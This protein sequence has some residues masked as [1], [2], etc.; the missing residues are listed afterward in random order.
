VDVV[1]A[2]LQKSRGSIAWHQ[3]AAEVAGGN[4]SIASADTLR[5]FVMSLP[6]STYRTTRMHPKLDQ[7]CKFRRY[8]WTIGFWIFWESAKHFNSVAVLLVHMDE[9]W[10]YAIVVRTNNKFVPAL[11]CV[12]TEHAIHHQSHIYTVMVIASTAFLPHNNDI[13]SG[14]IGFKISF[15][16]VGQMIPASR[17]TYRRQ[18][19]PEGGWHHPPLEEN[20]LRRK[21]EPIFK[22]M[23]ITG[24]KEGMPGKE[25]Y[26]LLTNF[27]RKIELPKLD[28]VCAKIESDIGKRIVV[29]YQMDG[30][31]PHRDT[32]LNR[33]LNAEFDKRGWMHKFQPS[34]SPLTNVKDASLFPALSK[35]VT[36]LQG[37]SKGSL[38]L[39][40]EELF[41]LA[42]EAWDKLPCSTIAR[43]YASL[44]QIVN[45]INECKGGD[46]FVRTPGGIHCGVRQAFVPYYANENSTEPSGVELLTTESDGVDDVL[47]TSGLKYRTPDVAEY[48][49]DY[50]KFLSAQ[51]LE[52]LRKH[53]P[54]ECDELD[55]VRGAQLVNAWEAEGAWAAAEGASTSSTRPPSD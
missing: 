34:N 51:E 17:T 29:R 38:A 55:S 1:A 42:S 37:L 21:G 10:F 12:P 46:D 23:E 7:S 35:R 26:S 15:E 44:H 19:K 14:G 20:I 16:R 54:P 18:Y 11:G 36:A 2:A 43:A 41:K 50:H 25:K 5:R 39:E 8:Q 45:A 53:L 9:K 33:E 22:P 32:R 3:L 52:V 48:C 47:A 28:Q 30:A 4:V 31:G 40:G 49:D 27:F 6:N 13:E 24:S